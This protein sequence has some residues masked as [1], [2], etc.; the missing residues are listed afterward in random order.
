MQL[1]PEISKKL[2]KLLDNLT[3]ENTGWKRFFCRWAIGADPLRDDAKELLKFLRRIKIHEM[4]VA[5]SER[6]AAKLSAKSL[7]K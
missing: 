1:S 3:Q 2:F 7:D 4:A 5:V 6:T